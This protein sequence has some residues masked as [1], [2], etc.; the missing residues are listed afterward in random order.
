M[1][2]IVGAILKHKL[3]LQLGDDLHDTLPGTCQEITVTVK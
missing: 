2:V 1:R 3:A